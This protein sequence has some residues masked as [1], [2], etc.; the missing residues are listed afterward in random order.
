[1]PR[2]LIE[3]YET[4]IYRAVWE[5][6]QTMGAPRLWGSFW[7]V[8]CLF[9][10]LCALSVGGVWWLLGVGFLWLLGQGL[11]IVLT[12]WEPDWDLIWQARLTKQYRDYYEAG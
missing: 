2:A 12:Y 4:E 11:L 7:M 1:M 5:R 3:G 8:C 6:P 10:G 9:G